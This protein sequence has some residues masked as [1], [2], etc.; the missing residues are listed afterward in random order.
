ME[1]KRR[2]SGL[3]EADH[4]VAMA[5]VNELIRE[6]LEVAFRW[7]NRT[8]MGA[9][10]E[11]PARPMMA[12][13]WH[14]SPRERGPFLSTKTG[15]QGQN[16]REEELDSERPPEAVYTYTRDGG[17]R[18]QRPKTESP[19]PAQESPDRAVP[20]GIGVSGLL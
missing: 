20:G 10:K 5:L 19:Q 17:N 12:P 2:F 4:P 1:G 18:V 11:I 13:W 14:S 8:H 7:P 9:G 3:V 6:G 16:L 15:P